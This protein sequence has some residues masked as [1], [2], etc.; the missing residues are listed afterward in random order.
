MLS[1]FAPLI[2]NPYTWG[3]IPPPP[4]VPPGTLG[5]YGS[6]KTAIWQ[7]S[8]Q[9]IRIST[10]KWLNYPQKVVQKPYKIGSGRE[11]Y[12]EGERPPEGDGTRHNRRGGEE[13]GTGD[14]DGAP[15]G[16]GGGI[17][18]K[19]FPDPGRSSGRSQQQFPENTPAGSCG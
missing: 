16:R 13:P 15:E 19:A 1:R 14:R 17:N 8:A 12:P 6:S 3:E 2:I 7:K 5:F 11:S 18:R 4:R 10:Q 9:N